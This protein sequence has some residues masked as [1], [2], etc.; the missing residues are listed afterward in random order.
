MAL[1]EYA[2]RH[3]RSAEI[4]KESFWA[5][6]K[7]HDHGAA[8]GFFDE[9]AQLGEGDQEELKA[10]LDRARQ[11]LDGARPID[12]A[13]W[14]ARLQSLREDARA[15]AS[16]AQTGRGRVAYILTGSLPWMETGYAMRSQA[17]VE[18]LQRVGMD[19]HCITRPGFPADRK[20]LDETAQYPAQ[21]VVGEVTYRHIAEPSR[22]QFRRDT[23]FNAAAVALVEALTPLAPGVVMAA[24]DYNNALPALLAA[25]Q[26][27]LPFIYDVRGFWELSRLAK[28]PHYADDP[29][30]AMSVALESL[31][32]R[33][34][35]QVFT[36]NV[37]MRDELVRRGVAET[38][39]TLT[40]NA[41][42][43][44]DHVPR[45]RDTALAGQL[46]IPSGTP[47]I[48]YIGSFNAYE[49]LDDLV[50]ACGR[51]GIK[52]ADFRL[53]LVGKSA[54]NGAGQ[55]LEA[56]LREI[57]S[58][59][60]IAD[61]LIMPGRVPHEA[62]EDWYSLID[63]APFPRKATSVTELVSPMKPLEAMAMAKLVIVTDIAPLAEMIEHEKT[64]LL[65][66]PGDP[67]KL[68]AALA[69][70]LGDHALRQQLGR[71]GRRWAMTE[72]SWDR[73]ARS[74]KRQIEG[75]G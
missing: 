38:H 18:A 13:A 68:E 42:N 51:L 1:L 64:G 52:G 15:R 16:G 60:G 46:G 20:G 34:A 41:C 58:A 4:L 36:L 26:M 47:V 43:P 45:P 74:V 24:P 6:L 50:R 11:K 29:D 53:L 25:R 5:A 39:I 28:N 56:Q 67:E 8:S 44:T 12:I 75:S 33:N 73:V 14:E 69:R 55:T 19:V 59:A 37:P 40:P 70:A 66:P 63:I 10:W 57:A 54:G 7:A 48:G 61:R 22:N 72:R 31:I 35:D 2:R 71:A 21:S 65:V 49:G 32:A 62:V 30:F 27:G 23:Y 17:L 3:V 9:I